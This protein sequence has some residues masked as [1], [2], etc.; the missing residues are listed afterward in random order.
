MFA[1][2]IGIFGG[3]KMKPHDFTRGN[4][5]FWLFCAHRAQTQVKDQAALS[6]E[7]VIFNGSCSSLKG[8]Q[9]RI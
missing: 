5:T 7:S 8:F 1:G 2:W 3:K 9:V 4:L 6:P